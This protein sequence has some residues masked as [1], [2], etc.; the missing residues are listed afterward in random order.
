MLNRSYQKSRD[1]LLQRQAS[2]RHII[3]AACV[4]AFVLMVCRAM[5]LRPDLAEVSLPGAAMMVLRASVADWAV[6]WG[7]AGLF[8]LAAQ[9]G[10]WPRAASLTYLILSVLLAGL[11]VGNITAVR[12]LGGPITMQWLAFS[13]VANSSYMID[14]MLSALRLGPVLAGLAL[15]AGYVLVTLGLGHLLRN[16]IGKLPLAF[17]VPLVIGLIPLGQSASAGKKSNPVLAMMSSVFEDNTLSPALFESADGKSAPPRSAQSFTEILPPVPRP[18]TSS[19]EVR[20]VIIYVMESTGA[21]YVSGYNP[22]Y[23]I[24]PVIGSLASSSLV[25]TDAYAHVPAS[26]YSLVSILA[27]ITPRRSELSMTDNLPDFQF[28]GLPALLA[29]HGYR[30]G[31]FSSPDDR[32]QNNDGFA[33][34]AGFQVV[35]D[36]RDFNC[37]LDILGYEGSAE[38]YLN[39]GNDHC[40]AAPVL[41]FIDKDP[42]QPFA[43]LLWTGMTHYPYFPGSNPQHYVDDPDQNKYLNA[44]REGDASLGEL[45][46]G[47][48]QRGLLD[49][50]LL[51]VVGDHGEAFGEHGQYSHA[52]D[53]YE[54]NLRIPMIFI[55]PKLFSGEKVDRIAGLSAVAPTITDLLGF[56]APP[57]W[58]GQSLFAK[59][60]ANGLMFFTAWN[61]MQIGYREGSTKFVLN[62]NTKATRL[63]DLAKDPTEQTDLSQT[64]PE[65]LAKASAKLASWVRLHEAQT[66]ALLGASPAPAPDAQPATQLVIQAS[67]TMFKDPPQVRV[68]IDGQDLGILSVTNA[69]SNADA[70]VDW[71]EAIA[72]AQNFV[73]PATVGPCPKMLELDFL[74]DDWA[75]EGLTGD[76]NVFI[77]PVTVGQKVYEPWQYKLETEGAGNEND[78]VFYLW[79]K[80]TIEVPLTASP[81]CIVGDL[82]E[83][84]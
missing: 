40:L 41:D 20:N 19:G 73:L 6:C 51:V 33:S 10:P 35:R 37:K 71:P 3:A 70:A 63:T 64:E 54:E 23:D 25:V 39:T 18:D 38:S 16:H 69:V 48:R 1:L 4:L 9:L 68:R 74:N 27:G 72:K 59:D 2:V 46:E 83:L 65:V 17:M 22:A 43:A 76:N 42:S 5:I 60:R 79:R 36:S 12:M 8:V 45:V 26:S 32:F 53:V 11:G 82:A 44:V 15:V 84:K 66:E 24:T 13:D 30:T 58:Q 14:T 49:S 81:D 77:G 57:G 80:G 34:K 62:A 55:N 78:S 67:G 52:T 31:Y 28:T 75:G 21:K 7:L 61:G 29:A 50:T 56:S 47:L